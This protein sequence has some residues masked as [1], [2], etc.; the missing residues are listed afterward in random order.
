MDIILSILPNFLIHLFKLVIN[1]FRPFTVK[2][3][4]IECYLNGLRRSDGEGGFIGG[5]RVHF[6]IEIINKKD[7]KFIIN[8]IYCRAMHQDEILQ[9][10]IC[11]YN[12]DAYKKIAFRSTYEPLSTIDISPQSS[13]HY[14]VILTPGGD[15]NRCDKLVLFYKK[16]IKKRKI[17]I[18]EKERN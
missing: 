5:S 14:D 1:L 15:L 18:W 4:L 16:G 11:C 17:I 3:N 12:K 6:R 7:K 8:K 2:V 13:E 10:N 9:D